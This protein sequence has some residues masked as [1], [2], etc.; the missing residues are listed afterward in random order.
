MKTLRNK[1]DRFINSLEPLVLNYENEITNGIGL[2]EDV[3]WFDEFEPNDDDF[4]IQL[5]YAKEYFTESYDSN[6]DY[7]FTEDLGVIDFEILINESPYNLSIEQQYK[8]KSKL[9]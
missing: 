7:Q 3:I 4:G 5:K 2:Y 9:K 8:L 1:V 6:T